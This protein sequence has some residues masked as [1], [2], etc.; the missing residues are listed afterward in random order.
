MDAEDLELF[1]RSLRHALDEH[2]GP[3]L[4]AALGDLGWAEA[5]EE[6]RETAV[7][8]LFE[9]LGEVGATSSSL[10]VVLRGAAGT[11]ASA[12]PLL[13]P[14][15]GTLTPPGER[16]GAVL[17]V[18]GLLRVTERPE[19]VAVSFLDEDGACRA[20]AV[21]VAALSTRVVHGLDPSLGLL[22][23]SG[24][25]QV[26]ELSGLRDVSWPA[27]LGVGSLAVAHEL[28]GA[29]RA[30][31]ELARSHALERIQFD[32]PIATFQAVRHRLA[33]AYLAIE[34]AH[35]LVVAA[36]EDGTL[37]TASMAKAFAGRQARVTAAHCQ[38]VLAGMGFTAEHPFHRHLRRVVVLDQLFGGHSALTTSLGAQLLAD[39]A[40]PVLFPL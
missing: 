30:M 39:R 31:L 35:S 16:D 1:T 13:L 12:A 19:Q 29:S 18:H 34:A 32:K 15:L 22:E 37:A 5:L 3:A 38:Q 26:D 6:E 24:T 21:S 10:D 36:W 28:L 11:S 4:D 14:A 2:R 25:L 17:G 33:E 8:V 23:L 20:G 27:V 7:R 40:L 9:L